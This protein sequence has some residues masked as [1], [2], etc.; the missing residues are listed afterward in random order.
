MN[1]ISGTLMILNVVAV[2]EMKNVQNLSL[3]WNKTSMMAWNCLVDVLQ[4]MFQ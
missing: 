1:S 2:P 3:N 4:K